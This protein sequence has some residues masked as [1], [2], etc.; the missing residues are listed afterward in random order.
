MLTYHL[1]KNFPYLRS[2]TLQFFDDALI[3]LSIII[4]Q[5]S[6]TQR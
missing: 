5:F 1:K 4:F 2:F 6:F 3:Y